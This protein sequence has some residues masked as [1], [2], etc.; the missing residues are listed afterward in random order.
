MLDAELSGTDLGG[1]TL[2]AAE[3]GDLQPRLLQKA[4]AQPVPDIEAFGEAS[5]RI[6]P[7]PAIGENTIHVQH[8]QSDLAQLSPQPQPAQASHAKPA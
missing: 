7:E 2:A 8:Q 3:E 1:A 5:V 4:D 6:K